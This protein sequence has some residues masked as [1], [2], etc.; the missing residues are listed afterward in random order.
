LAIGHALL[1]RLAL[2]TGDPATAVHELSHADL[3]ASRIDDPGVVRHQVALIEALVESGDAAS[4]RSALAR[5]ETAASRHPT[6]WATLAVARARAIVADGERA[7][8]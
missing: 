8:E 7:I 2:M 3:L 5:F 6:R 1:G 4:A